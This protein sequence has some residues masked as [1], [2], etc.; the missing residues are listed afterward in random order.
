[1]SCEAGAA[2]GTV[3]AAPLDVYW[4]VTQGCNFECNFCFTSSAPG[5]TADDLSAADRERI[6]GMI[7]ESGCLRVVLTG[8]EPLIV[9]EILDYVDRLRARGIGVKITTNGALLRPATVER[10]ARAG[11]R[12]Q[13]SIESHDPRLNDLLMG[14]RESRDRVLE[15]L[16]RARAAGIPCEVKVTLQAANSRNLG[17]L[18]DALH[19]LGVE[20][21]DVSEASPLGRAVENWSELEVSRDDMVRAGAEAAAARAAGIPVDFSSTRLQ[22]EENGVPAGCSLG[23]AR[24]R[25]VLI[26]ERGDMRPCAASQTFGWKNNVLE[27]GLIGAWDRLTELGKFRD[28][29]ELEGECRTCELV[30][31]CK[32]GC[33]GIAYGVW[34]HFKGP[35]P[36]CPK[37]GQREGRRFY[38]RKITPVLLVFPDGTTEGEVA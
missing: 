2:G 19:A 20:R 26:D 16:A 22:N 29:S 18:F 34:G 6:L 38:G 23:W 12:L 8:G 37:L 24:P 21:I 25:T 14:A 17:G 1:M 33:R 15:G 35:D 31:T 32:G 28:A 9:P 5:T 30:E 27:H 10:L 4:S 13:I 3:L 11:V 36:Y 7:L